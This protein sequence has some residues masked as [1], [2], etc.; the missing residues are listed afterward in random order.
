MGNTSFECKRACELKYNELLEFCGSLY[1][2]EIPLESVL[3]VTLKMTDDQQSASSILAF[4]PNE[5][6][7]LEVEPHISKSGKETESVKDVG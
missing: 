7:A 3:M 5:S 4:P 2:E 6:L 1:M